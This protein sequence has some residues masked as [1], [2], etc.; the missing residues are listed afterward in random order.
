M[1]NVDHKAIPALLFRSQDVTIHSASRE[2]FHTLFQTLAVFSMLYAFSWLI[3]R[4]LNF[5][6]RRFGTP[7][8]IFTPSR[9]WRWNIQ[10]VPK[11][12]HIK[13]RRRRI[14][15]KKAYKKTPFLMPSGSVCSL[16]FFF[17]IG[18]AQTRFTA[19]KLPIL[20]RHWSGVPSRFFNTPQRNFCS[21]RITLRK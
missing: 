9:L 20:V 1:I 12:R 3:P 10:C 8:P 11:R 6:R 17:D 7:C 19:F 18:L 21:K 4:R 5:I 14:T 16:D 13:F 15:H 2:Q